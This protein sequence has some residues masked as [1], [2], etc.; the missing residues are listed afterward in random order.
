MCFSHKKAPTRLELFRIDG[1]LF[2]PVA[3][4][5]DIDFTIFFG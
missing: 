1:A 2:Q 4:L 3:L 5:I